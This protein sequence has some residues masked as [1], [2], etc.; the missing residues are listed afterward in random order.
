[1]S[2]IVGKTQ[3]PYQG[4][5]LPGNAEVITLFNTVTAFGLNAAPHYQL[6]WAD[7]SISVDQNT[8]NTVVLQKSE[9][10]TTW[11]T[12]ASFTVTNAQVSNEAS[13]YVAPHKNW[14]LVYTNG[15]TPQTSF[16]VDLIIDSFDRAANA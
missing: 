2:G 16:S 6:Y 1:M 14:R 4:T 7:L 15:A 11:V 13:F 9:N 5:A 12:V 10:G 8:N 3:I